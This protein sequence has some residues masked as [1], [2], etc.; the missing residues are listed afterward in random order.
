MKILYVGHTYTVRAN[1]AKIAALARL[2][3][4]ELT[5]VTPQG[6]KGPLYNNRTDLFEGA[7]NVDHKILRAYFIGKESAYFFGPSLFSLI[8]RLKPDIVHVEQGAYAISYA[9]VL[10]AVKLFS[11]HSQALFFTWWNL[12]YQPR[13]IKRFLER[14]NF[15]NSSAAIAGNAAARD[16]LRNHGFNKP[17]SVLPQL[18]IELPSSGAGFQ[19]E[20]SDILPASAGWKPAPRDLA[21]PHAFIIGYAG[22]ITVEKGVLDLVDA[23]GMMAKP[24]DVSLYVVGAG[25]ALPE[26]KRREAHLGIRLHHHDAVRNE[27]IPE[28]LALMDVLVLPSRSTPNWVEQFGHI[29]LEAMAAGVPVV[30]SSSGEIPNVIGDAGVVFAE[31]DTIALARA[32]DALQADEDERRRLANRAFLRLQE[33]FTNDII[34]RE[35]F[36]LYE[37]L[38]VKSNTHSQAYSA[39]E[40]AH[41]A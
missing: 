24:E 40:A 11:P 8:A 25:T 1:H 23:V 5:L 19:P 10:L 17:I 22:R 15:A 21:A 29:L 28:Y 33:R 36:R 27:D 9:E 31:G 32:L 12:P 37:S 38:L 35:Q 2:P 41:A 20:R 16:I 7:P 3:G 14:F 39:K 34:A 4:V 6:W 26:L 18:G 13:G 30:G